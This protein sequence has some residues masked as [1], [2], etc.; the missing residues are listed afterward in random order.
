MNAEDVGRDFVKRTQMWILV[1][2]IL[3]VLLTI[4]MAVILTNDDPIRTITR[5]KHLN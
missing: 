5:Y 2:G 4:T 3:P 1:A